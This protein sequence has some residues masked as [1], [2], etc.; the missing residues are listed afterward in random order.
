MSL[1][2]YAMRLLIAWVTM[3]EL[4]LVVEIV[5]APSW[6]PEL[7]LVAS[8]LSSKKV[9]F[10]PLAWTLPVPLKTV[11]KPVV[12]AAGGQL[13]FGLGAGEL[14][15]QPHLTWLLHLVYDK[16]LWLLL[17]QQG[18]GLQKTTK[19]ASGLTCRRPPPVLEKASNSCP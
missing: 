17:Q 3:L 6:L 12:V 11:C 16:G 13:T 2:P 1:A 14:M 18:P 4:A 15:V 7:K 8:T 19:L 9:A 10:C 5:C